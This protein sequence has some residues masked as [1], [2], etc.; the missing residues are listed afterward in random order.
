M[1]ISPLV[2]ISSQAFVAEAS[3]DLWGESRQRI[4][5]K[6]LD[7]HVSTTHLTDLCYRPLTW[8]DLCQVTPQGSI[9]GSALGARAAD[10]RAAHHFIFGA[11]RTV[12]GITLDP[13]GLD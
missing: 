13:E 3:N 2:D 7:Q 10:V 12:F 4:T 11:A 9:N 5:T 6:K 1:S 8:R